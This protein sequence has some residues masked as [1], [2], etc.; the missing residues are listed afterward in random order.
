MKALAAREDLQ[1][2][3]TE[4]KTGVA[5][6]ELKRLKLESSKCPRTSNLAVEALAGLAS[7]ED[8]K[9]VN[10]KSSSLPLNQS[11]LPY[12]P[13]MLLQIKGRTHI[14]L[15]LVDPIYTSI[16]QGDCFIFI[17]P[18]KLYRYVGSYANFI[19]QSRCKQI[20]L[21]ILEHKDLGCTAAK[22][23]VINAGIG[24]SAT[25]FWQL[26]GRPDD[27]DVAGA[28]HADEDDLFE[29]SLI[30][31]NAAYEF[32]TDQL[33]PMERY[34][35]ALPRVEMLD[36]KKVL[37]FSFGSEVYVWNGK[38]A[39]SEAKRGALRLAQELFSGSYDYEMCDVNPVTFAQ[40]AGQR[41]VTKCVKSGTKPDWCLL[42]K[43]TQNMET[44]L[45]RQKFANWP[46]F[47]RDDL[48]KDYIAFGGQ[49]IKPLNG[50]ELFEGVPYEEPN[51]VLENANLGRGNFYYDQ[52]T[53][54]HF[55][56]HTQSVTKWRINEFNSDDIDADLY[57]HF[58]SAETYI[59]RWMY[60]ISITV[61]E[62]TGDVSKRNT[63]GRDRC[64][65]FCWQGADASTNE[66]GA[67]ALLTDEL[68]KAKG[69]QMR[70][71]Q[72]EEPTAFLRLFRTMFV[73]RGNKDDVQQRRNNWR[74]FAC[75]GN[76]DCETVLIEVACAMK[77]LR[78][79]ASFLL[80]NG[81]SGRVIVWHG[82]KSMQHTK[83]V[84][85]QAA[86]A[87]RSKKYAEL[88]EDTV[89]SVESEQVTEGDESDRFYEAIGSRNREEYFSMLTSPKAYDFTPRM[90]RFS[91]TNGKF[92][93]VEIL[94]QLRSVIKPF[95]LSPEPPPN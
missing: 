84:A 60:Q 71:T 66:K 10:L 79:R 25:E 77:Q 81:G 35:G 91:S 15:R 13:T 45:F 53:M 36:P 9:S 20:C 5:D 18:G 89:V 69:A 85:W 52:D 32:Q 78:S 6:R 8:F 86:E 4:I 68:N 57:G 94:S 40:V 75:V 90:F 26:L 47:E 31:T 38:N 23:I 21:S 59:V 80:V 46:E 48:E 62:L 11:W 65:Y 56:I 92:E 12:K 95:A 37:V 3:Y 1:S 67:A 29:A 63:V 43:V 58:Y 34:W 74:L 72:S 50:V 61:R 83:E 19:E 2:E 14:Q 24:G 73:H 51:L 54:R 42:A 22:E 30:E 41:K 16:N 33:L 39:S 28:G 49:Q 76:S 82:C 55:D 88:F 87:I 27:A 17:A 7:V 93:A 64:V 44:I 70:I